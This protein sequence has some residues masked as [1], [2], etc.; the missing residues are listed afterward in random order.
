[1]S[2]DGMAD[3]VVN[4]SLLESTAGALSMLIEEFSNASKIV[5]ASQGEVA[6]PTLV[7]ALDDFAN[8]WTVHRQDLLSSM[9]AVYKMA[10]ESHKAY[11]ATDDKLAQDLRK[12][13]VK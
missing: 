11:I 8:D 2:G 4:L 5:N 1:M 3:L 13:G 7:S 12:Q 9:E 10:T 6:E